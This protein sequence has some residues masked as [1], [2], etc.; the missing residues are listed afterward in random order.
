MKLQVNT[1]GAW[2]DVIE[3]DDT[4]DAADVAFAAGLLQSAAPDSKWCLVTDD[5]RRIWLDVD[6]ESGGYGMAFDA[7]VHRE[8][9]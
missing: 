5:G 1:S 3:F 6:R 8:S 7:G 2:R 9:F 4:A